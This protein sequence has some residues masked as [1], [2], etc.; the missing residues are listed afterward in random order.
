MSLM[1]GLESSPN[2]SQPRDTSSHDISNIWLVEWIL[3]SASSSDKAKLRLT[4]STWRR[5]VGKTLA[6][7]GGPR[8]THWAIEIRD[9]RYELQRFGYWPFFWQSFIQIERKDVRKRK[10][11]RMACIGKT[12]LSDIEIWVA[13]RLYSVHKFFHE[14]EYDLTYYAVLARQVSEHCRVYTQLW[15]NCQQIMLDHFLPIVAMD[16]RNLSKVPRLSRMIRYLVITAYMA[17]LLVFFAK[18]YQYRRTGRFI[19]PSPIT[20]FVGTELILLLLMMHPSKRLASIGPSKNAIYGKFVQWLFGFGAI[21]AIYT[22]YRMS[23]SLYGDALCWLESTS[24]PPYALSVLPKAKVWALF[25]KPLEQQDR[26]LSLFLPILSSCK[27][28]WWVCRFA[29]T[30]QTILIV[31]MAF[32]QFFY[33]LFMEADPPMHL[34]LILQGCKVDVA[35]GFWKAFRLTLGSCCRAFGIMDFGILGQK[36]GDW[37]GWMLTTGLP[38][39]QEDRKRVVF[40]CM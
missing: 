23:I 34:H 28:F 20:S 12:E 11:F 33:L 4:A 3:S 30:L 19:P 35:C 5:A 21:C 31:L 6:W 18:E 17:H 10:P 29:V 22:Y 26:M 40:I 13:G 36:Q 9:F 14:C 32:V 8:T 25:C 37:V 38:E 24:P 2:S 1:A 16:A 27:V 15:D 7:I 39:G